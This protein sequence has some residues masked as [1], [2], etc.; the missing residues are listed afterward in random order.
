MHFFV[1]VNDK[2]MRFSSE[3]MIFDSTIQ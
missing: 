2:Q 1:G 3:T